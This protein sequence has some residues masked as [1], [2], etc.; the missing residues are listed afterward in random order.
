[1]R[2]DVIV[3][4]DRD[5]MREEGRGFERPQVQ[6]RNAKRAQDD[7]RGNWKSDGKAEAQQASWSGVWSCVA[8]SDFSRLPRRGWSDR[9][10]TPSAT[11][12]GVAAMSS[13]NDMSCFPFSR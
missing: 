4:A 13:S 12:A 7:W 1:M 6:V 2:L 8:S 3:P 11:F 5:P 9:L 10:I